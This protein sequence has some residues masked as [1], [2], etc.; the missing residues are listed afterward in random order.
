MYLNNWNSLDQMK[1]DF[2]PGYSD[3]EKYNGELDGANVLLASYGTPNYEGHAFVLFERSGKLYE[4]NGSHCSCYGLEGQW[5]PEVTAIEVL[6]HRL[7]HGK[8][9]AEEYDENPF[10]AELRTV[11]DSLTANA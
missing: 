1:A 6:R 9:G 2:W 3:A 11:L 7:E 10:S 4:V 8:L 5:K